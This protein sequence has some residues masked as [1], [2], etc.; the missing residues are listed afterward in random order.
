MRGSLLPRHA[1]PSTS[2]RQPQALACMYMLSWMLSGVLL[3]PA[4]LQGPR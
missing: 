3:L 2:C 1:V 4:P